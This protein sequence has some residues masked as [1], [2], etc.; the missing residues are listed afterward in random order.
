M[1]E[2][3]PDSWRHP[4]HRRLAVV[5]AVFAVWA[6]AIQVRLIYLQVVRHDHYT[7]R[8]E[9]QHRRTIE[10]PAKRGEI[11]DRNDRV[12][13]YSVDA[14]SI[15]AV[16]SEIEHPQRVVAALCGVLSDCDRAFRATLLERFKRKRAF[17]WVS[18]QVSPEEARR[19]AALDLEGIGFSKESR[20][21]YP[22]T[23]LAAQVLGWVGID[24][25]GLGGIEAAYDDEIRGTPGTA[26]VQTD[27]RRHPFS[28]AEKP[29]TT[30]ATVQLTID[31]VLQWIAERE[32]QAGIAEHRATGGTAIIMDPWTGEVL[33]MANQPT[34]NPN[35]FARVSDKALLK[36]RAIQ[37]I[38]EPGSTFKVVTASAALE[39]GVI[40]PGDVV[41][42]SQ[43]YIQIGHRRVRDVHRY[44]ALTFEDVL[45]KSSNVGA[46]K[47]GFKLGAE[48]LSRYVRRFGFGRTLTPDLHGESPGIVWS[49]LTDSALASVSMGYQ[50][51]VTP[52][53]MA[54]AVSSVA[55]GGRLMEPRLVRALLEDGT[56]RLVQPKVLRQTITRDTAARL[57]A[58]MEGVVERGTAKASRIDGFTVAGK[59]GTAAK[60]VNG[61]YSKSE[62][63]SSFV[64]FLPSRKPA[65]TILVVIDS[66][67]RGGYYGGAVA[68][69][70][71]K[72]IAE[73]AIR[74][75]ALPPTINPLPPVLP[76]RQPS[77]A[78]PVVAPRAAPALVRA[79]GLPDA[80]VLPDLRG[81][82]ARDA[83]TT[84]VRL[85]LR[86]RLRGDGIVVDQRPAAGTLLEDARA[87]EL[88][89]D[90]ELPSPPAL[91]AQP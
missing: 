19:V 11:L 49:Q 17:A 18:R 61:V 45:I 78:V 2:P 1:P 57:T 76:P 36:N 90:R 37:D 88:F 29:P 79:G 87:C 66:P 13:A 39:E 54:T 43:G 83:L 75:L 8:A 34:F 69:P 5:V 30:G 38:Y 9:R 53:Q 23:T 25:R 50:I 20:R 21:Y 44:G 35:A 68:A 48:R 64:G 15:Y 52:L 89:L 24:N 67:Q 72:R 55:N 3:A 59:T 28:R 6:L 81:M 32:L 86:P 82:S 56:R 65:V 7:A 41:D 73:A 16:P 80:D 10:I 51:G 74:H 71:F 4:I 70:I 60:L 12:M 63:M 47:V 31:E 14:D 46:I 85:G 62:Y 77:P 40:D 91:E 33:A 58:I 26:L 22:N 42:V 84:L 27:A